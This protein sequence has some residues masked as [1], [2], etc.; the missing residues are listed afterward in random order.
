MVNFACKKFDL[1]EIIKC[2]LSLT[3]IECKI[4]KFLLKNEDDWL[5]STDIA[6]K[7]GVGRSTAQKA[8]KKLNEKKILNQRQQN[9][10]GGG[11]FFVYQIENK[12]K[13]R[14]IITDIVHE[15]VNDFEKEINKW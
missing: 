11:Y 13:V 8:V 5:S 15:W 4:L 3:K 6:K 10:E 14:K 2:S 7:M 9:I 12:Q 1:S